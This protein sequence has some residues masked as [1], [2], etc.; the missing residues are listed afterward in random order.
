MATYLI[1]YGYL[2]CNHINIF[3]TSPLKNIYKRNMTVI[4]SFV[5]IHYRI[6]GEFHREGYER[7]PFARPEGSVQEY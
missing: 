7:C 6:R 3:V 5:M 4:L 1:I 2:D